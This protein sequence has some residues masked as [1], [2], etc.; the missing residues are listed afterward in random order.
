MAEPP[1]PIF[2]SADDVLDW[3]ERQ[4]ECYEFVGGVL[5]LISG[6]TANHDLVGLKLAP[7]LGNAP[8]G[9]A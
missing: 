5:Q 3:E 7:C 9:R 6:G 1:L 2:R 4:A 8:V